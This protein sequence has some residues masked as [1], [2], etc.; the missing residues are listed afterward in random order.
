MIEGMS[1]KV[2]ELEWMNAQLQTRC[3]ELGIAL[4][5]V[6]AQLMA[7]QAQLEPQASEDPDPMPDAS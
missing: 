3:L 4:D 2:R 6:S 5:A 7:A 1:A